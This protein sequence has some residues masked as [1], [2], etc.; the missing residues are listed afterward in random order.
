MYRATVTNAINKGINKYIGL[1]DTTFKE[2]HSNHKGDYK[3]QKYHNCLE[4]A[5]YVWKLKEKK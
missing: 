5:K 3:H 1:A 4:L 2:R